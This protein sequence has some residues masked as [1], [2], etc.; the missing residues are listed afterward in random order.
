MS[1]RWA[2][3]L[4]ILAIGAVVFVV[5]MIAA[6]FERKATKPKA[7]ADAASTTTQRPYG[8]TSSTTPPK[9]SPSKA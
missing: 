3:L 4:T 2:A 1:G 8:Y 6:Y 9:S 5:G 7:V